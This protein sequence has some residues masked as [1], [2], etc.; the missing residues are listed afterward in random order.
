MAP[1]ESED[2][3]PHDP[4]DQQME[5]R[6]LP[7]FPLPDVILFPG[8]VMPLHIFE[9]RYRQMMRDLLDNSG[10]VILGTVLGEDK[11]QL[12]ELAPVQPVA[13]LGRLQKYQA[14]EDGRFLVMILGEKR[15]RI[16]PHIGNE[17]YPQARVKE[18]DDSH[19]PISEQQL[20]WLQDSIHSIKQDVQ[21]P[22]GTSALQLS[23]LLMMITPM[24]IEQRYEIYALPTLEER[25][26][27][28]LAMQTHTDEDDNLD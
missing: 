9:P 25:I 8:Q 14:L 11:E 22:E 21:L 26:D 13:G 27:K 10:E 3:E 17:L 4:A 16:R 12:T 5:A 24:S 18:I 23:D 1:Y 2:N 6:I 28:V 15:V 20:T 19:G 7:L